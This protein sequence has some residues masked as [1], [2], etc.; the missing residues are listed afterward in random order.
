M[1][2]AKDT[3]FPHILIKYKR[4]HIYEG[5]VKFKLM[6]IMTNIVNYLFKL[7]FKPILTDLSVKISLV[8]SSVY[9]TFDF[10]FSFYHAKRSTEVLLS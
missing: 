6:I 10:H 4:F 8:S 5:S 3:D 7:L 9:H 1:M 2:H